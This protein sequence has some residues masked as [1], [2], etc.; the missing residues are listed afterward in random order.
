MSSKNDGQIPETQ[1]KIIHDKKTH[2]TD[3]IE[4]NYARSNR[5]RAWFI[6]A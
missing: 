2:E 6:Q 4:K 1:L 3:A 5:A